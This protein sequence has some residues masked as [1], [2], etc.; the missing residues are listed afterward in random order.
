MKRKT[1]TLKKNEDKRIRNGHVWIYSNE[2]ATSLKEFTPGEE[3]IIEAFDKTLLGAAFVNPHSLIAARLFSRQSQRFFDKDLIVSRIRQAEILRNRLYKEPYYRLIYGD[4]D[5]LP[6]IIADRFNDVLSLQLNTAGADI[7][8]DTI[9]AAFQEAIPTI[10]SILLKNDSPM[11]KQEGLE[12]FVREGF[13]SPPEKILVKENGISFSA[14]LWAG[15]KTGWFYDHRA[16]R[17]RLKDYVAELKVLDVFSYLGAFGVHAGVFGAKTVTCIDESPLS[18]TWIQE[19][20]QKNHVQDKVNV[21]TDDAFSALKNLQQAKKEFDVIILDPPAFI[22]K[23]K[24][25]KE[26]FIAYQRI[27]EAAIKLLSPNGILVSCSCSM[28]LSREDL[29]DVIKRAS[30]R[31]RAELQILERGSQAPDHPVHLAIPETDY[32]KMIIARRL[33]EAL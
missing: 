13:G 18:A 1:L 4:S 5:G 21:I 7:K 6:G 33:P 24:D 15:Q 22:K 23:Q 9:L 11:R 29:V 17:L 27:N 25:K 14:P 16:N 30:F 32:L 19:N 26:G 2:I 10:Q 28:H 8:T 3:V 12:L 31:A 20:A